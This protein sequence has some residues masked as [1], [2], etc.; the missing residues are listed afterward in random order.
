MKNLLRTKKSLI[1]FTIIF[2][3]WI[4]LFLLYNNLKSENESKYSHWWWSWVII[5]PDPQFS[6]WEQ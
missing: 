4:I 5:S 3:S 6:L 2:I 1:L